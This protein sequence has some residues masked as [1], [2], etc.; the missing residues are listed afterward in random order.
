MDFSMF[1]ISD[2]TD[3]LM[4]NLQSYFGSGLTD[5]MVIQSTQDASDFFNISEPL[6]VVEGWTTGVYNNNPFVTGDDLL[7]VSRE[8]LE[9][10][11]I[12]G[13]DGLDLVLTHEC[14]HRRLQGMNLGFDSHQEELCCDYM[15]GVRAGLNKI[16]I[17]EMQ[18]SLAD[19][20]ESDTHPAGFRRVEAIERGF[21]FAQE[22]FE[23]YGSAPTFS[24]C[25]DGFSA[26]LTSNDLLGYNNIN[27]APDW[28]D[29]KTFHG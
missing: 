13:K 1:D 14:A 12:S 2:F 17:T 21:N 27:L 10:M 22:Y 19:S 6:D 7:M 9:G 23:K 20:L 26:D 3:G 4:D 18:N 29:P 5:D 25:L 28:T 11:G 8:Q 24:D 16:D 15:A